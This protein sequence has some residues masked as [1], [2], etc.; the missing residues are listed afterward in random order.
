MAQRGLTRRPAST[1]GWI[2]TMMGRI[3]SRVSGVAC[4]AQSCAIVPTHASRLSAMPLQCRC[5]VAS[6]PFGCSKCANDSNRSLTSHYPPM[7]R[8]LILTISKKRT[9]VLPTHKEKVRCD[10][11]SPR[12]RPPDDHLTRVVCRRRCSAHGNKRL[13]L[14]L[15][16]IAQRAA[17]KGAS[18]MR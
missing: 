18:R 11:A 7:R 5:N 6:R 2:K 16:M 14:M 13:C 3:R 9:L 8:K 10:S 1:R 12:M 4:F 15:C 17:C